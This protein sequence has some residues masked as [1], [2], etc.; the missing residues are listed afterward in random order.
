MFRLILL[1]LLFPFGAMATEPPTPPEGGITF[2]YQTACTDL[3]TKEVGYC[4]VGKDKNDVTYV[5]F[6]QQDKLMKITT[7]TGDK[8]EIIWQDDHFASY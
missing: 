7:I 8:V 6:W 2:Y 3:A 5:T 1:L 4:Y